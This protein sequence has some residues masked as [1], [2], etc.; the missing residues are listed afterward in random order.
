MLVNY[1]DMPTRSESIKRGAKIIEEQKKSYKL[2]LVT[3]LDRYGLTVRVI[4]INMDNPLLLPS[5]SIWIDQ[6]N[7][8]NLILKTTTRFLYLFSPITGMHILNIEESRKKFKDIPQ[9][10]TVEVGLNT[11]KNVLILDG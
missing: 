3:L 5:P 4:N 10:I 8:C 6:D 2:N 11:P 9:L 1:F 7:N